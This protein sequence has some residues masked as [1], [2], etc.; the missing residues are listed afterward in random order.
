[1]QVSG[2]FPILY[3]EKIVLA[4]AKDGKAI[5]PHNK[6]AFR[7]NPGEQATVKIFATR[8]GKPLINEV[9]KLEPCNV[10]CERYIE[11]G[12]PVGQPPL[13]K[14]LPNA[15]TD[16]SGIVEYTISTIDPKNNRSFIDGQLYLFRYSF[17]D[18]KLTDCLDMCKTDPFRLLNSLIVIRAFDNYTIEGEPTW[19]DHVY[20]IFKQYAN[21]YPVMT[22]NFVDL[23]NYYEVI[24][25]RHRIQV[26]LE[27]PVSHPN[28][29]NVTRDLSKSKREVILKWLKQTN[30][31]IHKESLYTV[32]H[33][34]EDLQIALQLEHSTIP[35]YLTAWASIKESYN[36]QVKSILREIIIQEMMHMALVAN[37]I[38]AVGGKPSFYSKDFTPHYPSRLP[39]G[40]H[41]DLVVPIEKISL[42]LIR[43]IFMKIEQPEFE[44]QDR[45][46]H[47]WQYVGRTRSSHCRKNEN[48]AGCSKGDGN[49][50][51]DCLHPSDREQIAESGIR[52]KP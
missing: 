32:E 48:G 22:E 13:P 38:N 27:L 35:P 19:R 4:E 45:L 23:G 21:M 51:G 24:N 11:D 36:Q 9:V 25:Y 12:P 28:Y 31:L 14:V 8:F 50:H 43:N 26:C 29:M 18:Q 47:V 30:P 5:H 16:A 33:L 49:Y 10:N 42:A 46:G 52:G 44:L 17:H 40:V 39:G 3:C 2:T 7:K 1:M 20:P 41:P 6:W 15:V 37:I 34:R